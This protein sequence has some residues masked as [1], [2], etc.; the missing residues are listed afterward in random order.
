M[1]WNRVVFN[2]KKTRSQL[3]LAMDK[4]YVETGQC[5][6]ALAR[7]KF[8]VVFQLIW[9]IRYKDHRKESLNLG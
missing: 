4:D 2:F 5:N 3:I 7:D 9:G 1:I 6:V 8:P